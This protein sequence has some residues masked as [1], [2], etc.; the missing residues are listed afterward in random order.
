MTL[1]PTPPIV[2]PQTCTICKQNFPSKN[3]LFKH[4]KQVAFHTENEY[5]LRLSLPLEK[6]A[7]LYGYSPKPLPTTKGDESNKLTDGESVAQLVTKAV[8]EVEVDLQKMAKASVLEHSSSSNDSSDGVFSLILSQAKNLSSGIPISRTHGNS[9][10]SHENAAQDENTGA[11]SEVMCL[12][13]SP[14]YPPGEKDEEKKKAALEM[15]LN[16][17][18]IKISASVEKINQ[19]IDSNAIGGRIQVF[20]RL[21]VPKNFNA[22]TD[23]TNRKMSYLLP[24]DFFVGEHSCFTLD[25]FANMKDLVCFDDLKGIASH[26][27]WKENGEINDRDKIVRFM[28]SLKKMM[29]KFITLAQPLDQNDH[30]A[31]L[32]KK[33][34]NASRNLSRRI[35]DRNYREEKESHE[36]RRAE[37]ETVIKPSSMEQTTKSSSLEKN[38]NKKKQFVLRRKRYHNFTSNLMAHD[39]L[40]FRRLDR[41][42]HKSMKKRI[43][44][45]VS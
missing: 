24:I 2:K 22:E 41:F 32:E 42:H 9:T 39:F 18:N 21:K 16:E 33:N 37:S 5:V 20:G 15:W 44:K 28:F 13:I 38:E 45:S 43:S 10:R 11:L 40:A 36:C 30:S 7:I 29:K 31:V 12:R 26:N 4:L 14:M 25:D 1:S 34:N 3:A 35:K 27:V 6:V 17:V 8:Q 23:T 19:G